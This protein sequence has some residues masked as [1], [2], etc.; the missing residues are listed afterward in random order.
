MGPVITIIAECDGLL[1]KVE[2]TTMQL[3]NVVRWIL[4]FDVM[5]GLFYKVP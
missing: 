5:S 4:I 2:R 3:S 1:E